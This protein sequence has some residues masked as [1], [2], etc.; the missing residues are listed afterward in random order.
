MAW[1]I[2][3]SVS[4]W[5]EATAT[6]S[7][8]SARS[9]DDCVGKRMLHCSRYTSARLT[10]T[11]WRRNGTI[12]IVLLISLG[13]ALQNMNNAS[14]LYRTSPTIPCGLPQRRECELIN[15]HFLMESGS[16]S[17]YMKLNE[18]RVWDKIFYYEMHTKTIQLH[19]LS[20]RCWTLAAKKRTYYETT[21][22]QSM[23]VCIKVWHSA[24]P[25]L[26]KI[27]TT[28]PHSSLTHLQY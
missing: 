6:L 17:E 13:S 19:Y 18:S 5:S 12:W 16:T 25:S 26:N 28:G 24:P 11:T 20:I 1:Y 27:Q 14:C 21:F 3:S 23:S 8:G 7:R 15:C 22:T 10:G 2:C 9:N 4:G